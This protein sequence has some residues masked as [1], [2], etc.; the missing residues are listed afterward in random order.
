MN[1]ELYYQWT[2][3]VGVYRETATNEHCVEVMSED[4]NYWYISNVKNLAEY[5]KNNISKC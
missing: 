4:S 5:M 2:D 3:A 1:L